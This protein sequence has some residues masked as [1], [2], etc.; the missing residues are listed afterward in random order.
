MFQ[1]THPCEGAIAVAK[2][3]TKVDTVFQSTH[4][5]EG[6]I[7][8]L[9]YTVKPDTVFQSTHPCEGAIKSNVN[10]TKENIR[11]NPRTLVRVRFL[12]IL[13]LNC[14]LLFQSTH[15]CE[16]AIQKQNGNKY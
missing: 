3:T 1:S 8:N 11:F 16:G 10:R 7:T 12:H 5:C 4:P 9:P 13:F 14:F 2:R 15:P 6:A